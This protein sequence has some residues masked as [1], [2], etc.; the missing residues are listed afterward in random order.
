MS[1]NGNEPA[2]GKEYWHLDATGEKVW[3]HPGLTKREKIAAM[4]LQGLLA[5]S[6]EL[7][8]KGEMRPARKS[9]DMLCAAA[10]QMA[11]ELLK[12]LES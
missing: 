4:A 1:K 10:I 6:E 8:L 9:S 3:S 12:Q 2:Y 7:R 11:D 5:S